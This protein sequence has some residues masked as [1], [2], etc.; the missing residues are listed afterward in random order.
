MRPLVPDMIATAWAV[1]E[2]VKA[3]AEKREIPV[4]PDMAK[5]L[6]NQLLNIPVPQNTEENISEFGTV[7]YT[8]ATGNISSH[9]A[10]QAFSLWEAVKKA[11]GKGPVNARIVERFIGSIKD[12]AEGEAGDVTHPGRLGQPD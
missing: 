10:S 7:H 11:K 3:E 9:E 1:Y 12:L 2:T 5:T 6:I 4:G 8:S